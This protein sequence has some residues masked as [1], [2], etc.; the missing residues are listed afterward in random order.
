[1][2]QS[3]PTSEAG[4]SR[5]PVAVS[6]LVLFCGYALICLL[7]VILAV[8]QGRPTRSLWHELSLGLVMIAYAM[9]LL[10]FVLSGRFAWLSG[11]VGI[12]RTMRLHQLAGRII[13]VVIILHPF[14]FAGE[15]IFDRAG[16]SPE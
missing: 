12:D 4:I 14:L 3:S 16:M 2:V 9:T 7:P 8:V 6:P 15:G 5:R 10:Q 11:R 13:F 1:M